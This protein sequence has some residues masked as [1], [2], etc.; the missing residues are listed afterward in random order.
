MV[1]N[2]Y[3][4]RIEDVYMTTVGEKVRALR[5]ARKLTMD[6]LAAELGLT[7]SFISQ[8]E[9]G[10]SGSSQETIEAIAE[11]FSVSPGLL[12]DPEVEVD[13]LDEMSDILSAFSKL[14]PHKRQAARQMILALADD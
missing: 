11:F 1:M 9:R 14:P 13:Q 12:Q 5:K 2:C 7:Q 8:F 4:G 3:R 10:L 6:E